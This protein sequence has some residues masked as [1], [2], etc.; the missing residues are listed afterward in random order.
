MGSGVLVGSVNIP[1]SGLFQACAAPISMPMEGVGPDG[2]RMAIIALLSA[3]ASHSAPAQSWSRW[4]AGSARN[5]GQ[6]VE[7]AQGSN[8]LRQRRVRGG[9]RDGRRR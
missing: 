5:A 2:G 4:P 3:I 1:N 9:M 7:L 6:I 8:L